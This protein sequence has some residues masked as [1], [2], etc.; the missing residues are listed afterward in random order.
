[1]LEP[2]YLTRLS[3]DLRWLIAVYLLVQTVGFCVGTFFIEHTT[4]GS[5]SGIVEQ[6]NGNEEDEDAE[7]MKFK[8][9]QH[10]MLNLIHTHLLGMSAM[11]FLTGLLVYGTRLT[12]R[13]RRLLMVEPLLSALVTFGSLY[14]VW[15]GW[16]SMVY[17]TMIS[18]AL[19]TASYL[20]SVG[21]VLYTLARPL[22]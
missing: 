1:M 22:H 11:F 16:E 21:I 4:A 20:A 15:L 13:W 18:G 14:L 9:S 2:G 17:L 8:K 10:S 3:I 12:S 5:P 6:Y 7:E 19:M